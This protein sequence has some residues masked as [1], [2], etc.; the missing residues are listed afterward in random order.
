MLRFIESRRFAEDS[1]P[2]SFVSFNEI[3]GE[4]DEYEQVPDPPPAVQTI[5]PVTNKIAAIKAVREFCEKKFG[6]TASLK[7]S[8]DFIDRYVEHVQKLRDE[9]EAEKKALASLKEKIDAIT[10]DPDFYKLDYE[11]RNYLYRAVAKLAA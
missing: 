6:Q 2:G 11:T 1:R 3:N 8:K 5:D 4:W 7:D 9:A 10:Q